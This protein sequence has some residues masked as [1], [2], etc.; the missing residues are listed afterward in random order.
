VHEINQHD[1]WEDTY[2]V[3]VNMGLTQEATL[4]I[5]EVL[6]HNIRQ[7]ETREIESK[8]VKQLLERC[9]MRDRDA[10]NLI[11]ERLLLV[12][13]IPNIDQNDNNYF[14]IASGGKLS[15]RCLSKVYIKRDGLNEVL[16]GGQ[17]PLSISIRT[18][19]ANL[20]RIVDSLLM[21]AINYDQ[22]HRQQEEDRLVSANNLKAAIAMAIPCSDQS[23]M[24]RMRQFSVSKYEALGIFNS[25]TP[26][27]H[28]AKQALTSVAS[29]A[30][31]AKRKAITVTDNLT[32]VGKDA[33]RYM[34]SACANDLRRPAVQQ[35]L[36]LA[37]SQ[38]AKRKIINNAM[39]ERVSRLKRFNVFH[40][41]PSMVGEVTATMTPANQAEY[42]L[43]Q[44]AEK[45]SW[46]T[47]I[48]I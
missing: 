46:P 41:D 20:L 48:L 14:R 3:A 10:L 5:G 43:N 18:F 13:R 26:G 28:T 38:V 36:N 24:G 32:T 45:R 15:D 19:T 42:F 25:G 6:M 35:Q 39:N 16:Q 34:N 17:D 31:L 33:D 27:F 21:K 40:E 4:E 29:P 44:E 7:G 47:P 11:R 23:A 1:A 8:F 37:T 22:V 12:R 2:N 30:Q 9:G